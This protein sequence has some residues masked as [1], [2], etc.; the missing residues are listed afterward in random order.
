MIF[1]FMEVFADF[2]FACALNVATDVFYIRPHLGT[3]GIQFRLI[4]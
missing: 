4:G 2:F 1:E 3:T